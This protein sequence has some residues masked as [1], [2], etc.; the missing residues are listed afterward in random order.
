MGSMRLF[1]LS[2]YYLLPSVFPRELSGRFIVYQKPHCGLRLNLECA[3]R[4]KRRRRFV[5]S[6]ESVI[7]SGVALRLPPHS[8]SRHHRIGGVE[9]LS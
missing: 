3:G 4:A 9:R 6:A 8:K 2:A 7:Q 5:A 1:L